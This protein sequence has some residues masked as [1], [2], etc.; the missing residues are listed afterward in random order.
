MIVT[1]KDIWHVSTELMR[2][3]AIKSNAMH[4]KHGGEDLIKFSGP[5][6]G[7]RFSAG[8]KVVDSVYF[9]GYY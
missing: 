5:Y 6:H 8:E 9:C 1:Y 3:Y 2:V 4:E 7:E